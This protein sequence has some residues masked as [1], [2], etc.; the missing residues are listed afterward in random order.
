MYSASAIELQLTN[1]FVKNGE[2]PPASIARMKRRKPVEQYQPTPYE[3]KRGW[4][5]KAG[6][7]SKGEFTMRRIYM[8]PEEIALHRLNYTRRLA[9]Q[10]KK[11]ARQTGF[12]KR[13]ARRIQRLFA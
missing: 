11:Q 4:Y 12:M 6:V 1:E 9:A 10:Q 7:D 13:V 2:T 3:I 8:A 5:L